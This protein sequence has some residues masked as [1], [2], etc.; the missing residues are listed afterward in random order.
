[1]RALPLHLLEKGLSK[2]LSY[3]RLVELSSKLNIPLA[4][5]LIASVDVTLRCN[6]KCSYCDIW[7]IKENLHEV[8]LD[9]LDRI[10]G[11]LEKLG[12]RVVSPSGGEPLIRN[13][14]EEIISLAKHYGMVVDVCTNGI[15]LNRERAIRL[16]EAGADSI[17]LSL[18]TLDPETHE[19]HRGVPFKLT[20][21]ALE[22]LLYIANKY[23]TLWTAVN[24]V[25]TRYNIGTLVAFANWISKY[26][27]GRISVTF[28]PYHQLPPIPEVSELSPKIRKLANEL[29][30]Y[31][32]D[33]S[34]Q[35]ELI[36]GPELRPIFEREVQELIRL[37]K[38]KPGFPLNNSEFYLKSMPD[39]L[40]DN[41]LP[42]GF[43][44]VAGYTGIV[45][46]SDLEV[47][48]CWRL[49]PIGDL[50]EEELVDIWFSE[51]Y[52]RQ[53]QAMKHLKCPG[54]ML[55]CHSR[56]P[57]WDEWFNR[58]YKSRSPKG[59]GIAR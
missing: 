53:R 38:L 35:N 17:I 28:Q 50:E 37:K 29:L 56:E 32:K 47:C 26:G 51:R 4:P 52:G 31:Y 24:C 59:R 1:M 33:K 45:I 10:F 11:S 43:D 49:P 57:G 40:F 18:D 25:I 3:K 22:S 48:P 41:K 27:E 14:F 55:L 23:P 12:V 6:S 42:D 13:D 7:R 21:E 5:P 39:F 9:N 58:V 54:C 19:R 34:L 36:P 46:R 2:L 44:C 20:K 15:L 8:S 30:P 16:A